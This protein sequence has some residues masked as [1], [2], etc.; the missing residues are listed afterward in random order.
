MAIKKFNDGKHKHNEKCTLFYFLNFQKKFKKSNYTIANSN[1][2]ISICILYLR[3]KK[4]K[5]KE[6]FSIIL[7]LL[8]KF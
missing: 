8:F 2:F 7:L 5:K 1:F 3:R 6:V 4:E